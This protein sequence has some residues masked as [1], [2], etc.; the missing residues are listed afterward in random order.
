MYLFL[1]KI[2]R[3]FKCYNNKVSNLPAMENIPEIKKKR[4]ILEELDSK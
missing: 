1:Q 2:M 3:I 4:K